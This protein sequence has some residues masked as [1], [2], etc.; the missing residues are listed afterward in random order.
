M[1]NCLYFRRIGLYHKIDT[2]GYNRYTLPMRSSLNISLPEEMKQYVD[3]QVEGGGFGTVSEYFRHLIRDDQ[4]RRFREDVDAK[5]L[6]ALDGSPP[7]EMTKQWREER[8][9][10]LKKRIANR[11]AKS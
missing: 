10:E 11:G 7:V 1:R 3:Q 9:A 4:R 5:L 2:D 8:R 6:A